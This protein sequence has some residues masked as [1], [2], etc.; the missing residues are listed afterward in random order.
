MLLSAAVNGAYREPTTPQD[1]ESIDP[2]K[3]EM[4]FRVSGVTAP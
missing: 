2:F 4:N 3:L 1:L